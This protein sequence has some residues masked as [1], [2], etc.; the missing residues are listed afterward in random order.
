MTLYEIDNAIYALIDK[1]TGE[2][3]DFDAFE[4]LQM[5][6]DD[7]IEN[8]ALWVKDLSAEVEAL[9]AE[10][11]RLDDRQKA[12]ERKIES[13]KK[14][15]TYALNGEGFNR[16]RVSIS[17]RK[18]EKT[19]ITTGFIEWAKANNRDDLLTYKEPTANLPAIKEAINGGEDVPFTEIV[20]KKNIGIK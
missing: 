8:V 4:Q 9:K 13:L 12:A 5:E 1:E 20:K 15:L 19:E 18:S 3:K 16:P 7:K 2:I 14:Y 10:K 17:F 6:R 11:K